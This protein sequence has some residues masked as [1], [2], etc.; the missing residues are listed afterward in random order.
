MISRDQLAVLQMHILNGKTLPKGHGRLIDADAIKYTHSIARSMD[1]GHNWNELCVTAD[2]IADN[3]MY[4]TLN[5]C[6]V[7][8]YKEDGLVLSKKE[9]GEWGLSNLPKEYHKLI[10]DALNEYS[11]DAKTDFDVTLARRYA[12]YM[13]GRINIS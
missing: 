12:D 2:E 10:S 11:S 7:L 8:A 4:L 5:L 9:G 3:T 1:D 6:R 13:T